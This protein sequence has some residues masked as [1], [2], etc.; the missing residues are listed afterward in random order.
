MINSSYGSAVT[1]LNLSEHSNTVKYDL[2]SDYRLPKKLVLF[3]L[4]KA[5]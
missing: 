2:K 1:L 5:L 3:A 4:M